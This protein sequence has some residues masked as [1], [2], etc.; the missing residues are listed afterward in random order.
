MTSSA[1]SSSSLIETFH[2]SDVPV[3]CRFLP[4]R[5]SVSFSMQQIMQECKAVHAR[6][7]LMGHSL[8]DTNAKAHCRNA[9]KQERKVQWHRTLA[10]WL[11]FVVVSRRFV[12]SNKVVSHIPFCSIKTKTPCPLCAEPIWSACA[13]RSICSMIT[14][15]RVT[16]WVPLWLNHSSARVLLEAVSDP[17]FMWV[18]DGKKS[19]VF[20]QA[21]LAF[22]R[23]ERIES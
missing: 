3:T 8:T 11:L 17:E 7:P 6:F 18:S 19:V 5:R 2:L 21:P 23:H 15:H 22:K 10:L 20:W 16:A 14:W 13:G 9:E 4:C 12:C 1:G